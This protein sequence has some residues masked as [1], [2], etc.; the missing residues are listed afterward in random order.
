MDYGGF[1][2]LGIEVNYHIS[3][4]QLYTPYAGE[5][6]PLWYIRFIFPSVYKR[7]QMKSK[8]INQNKSMSKI[9]LYVCTWEC[10]RIALPKKFQYIK[11]RLS[12]AKNK[13]KKLDRCISGRQRL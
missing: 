1:W 8:M 9:I 12:L 2:P 6:R 7:H 4:K 10:R 11:E 3:Y 13:I 5:N